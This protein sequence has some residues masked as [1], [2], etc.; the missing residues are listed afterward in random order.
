MF[1]RIDT[2]DLTKQSKISRK[3]YLEWY[4]KRLHEQ[5]HGTTAEQEKVM[6]TGTCS[7][8]L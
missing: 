4:I 3:E 8:S 5:V 7:F 2:F 1:Y 6:W